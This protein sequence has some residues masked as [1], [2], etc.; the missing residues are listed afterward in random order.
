MVVIL[1]K[2]NI[3]LSKLIIRTFDKV[4]YS[5]VNNEYDRIICKGGR[6]STKS[7]M[8]AP[9]III[10]VLLFKCDAVCMVKYD[11]KV[12][13]R[14]VST[15][16]EMLQRSKLEG[17]FKYKVQKKELVLLDGWN[18]KETNHSIKFTGVDDANKLKSFKPRSGTG[19]F[20][21]IWFEELTDFS[22]LAEVS[23]VIN[24]MARGEGA[25]TVIMSYNP[26]KST[27][28][29]VNDNYNIPCGVVLGHNS[30][31]Y[32]SEFNYS[33][34]N[35]KGNQ[36]KQIVKQLVHH[37]TYLD[38][39]ES[40]CVSWLG[41]TLQN[42]EMA[43]ENNTDQYRWEY[44]GE[45]IGTEGNIFKNIKEL[46]DNNYT[47]KEIFRGLDFGFTRDPSAYVEW[48]YDKATNSIYCHNEFV[49]KSIDNSTLAFNIKQ[50]NKHDFRVWA[51]SEDPRTINE[52]LKLGV[53]AIG[54]KKGSD[55]VRHGIK[56]L[57]SLNGIYINPITCPNT[58]REFSRYEYKLNKQ[59]EYTGE[60]GDKN[61][62]TIDA[63]RYALCMKINY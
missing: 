59:G 23:N 42:A 17:F 1:I 19:G 36:V 39:I 56:W 22:S 6:N 49:E 12:Y 13:E 57:Q 24:T 28:N 60:L 11:N 35:E 3:D 21:Y 27:S 55:S 16:L 15:F 38:V 54:V 58:Y 50:V 14:L 52:L 40:G 29:W 45:A 63:T 31:S 9:A 18:G 61:N 32:V 37:S 20:R 10:G 7:S 5:I 2:L 43:R 25:H 48:T 41:M 51:D 44:L 34:I 62:H 8:I 53:R 4:F 30:N 33:Y 46:K 26:P 47:Q